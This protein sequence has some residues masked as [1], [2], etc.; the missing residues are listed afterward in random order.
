VPTGTV[1]FN[2]GSTT[3]GT[4]TL[5]GTG[6]AS[7]TTS[8]LGAGT[9][10]VV[11]AYLGDTNFS[12]A[13]SPGLSQTINQASYPPTL[14]SSANPSAY[15]QSVTFTATIP[16][17]NGVA[18]TGNITFKDGANGLGVMALSNSTAAITTA[19]L[20]VGTHIISAL[21]SGDANFSGGNVSSLAVVVNQAG[22]SV[23]VVSSGNPSAYNQPV[24]FTATVTPQYGGTT[25]GTITFSDSGSPLANVA[26]VG[27]QA[28]FTTPSL[29]IG[30]HSITAAYSGDSNFTGSTSSAIAQLVNQAS[31]IVTVSSSA[32]PAV[33]GQQ[34]TFTVQVVGQY[35]GTLSGTVTFQAGAGV[36]G[37][38]TVSEGV[39]AAVTH[40]F[41]TAAKGL[42]TAVYSGDSNFA[43]SSAGV[44]QVINKAASS[45]NLSSNLNPSTYGQAVSFT[46]TVTS[47][48]GA[49]PS[50]ELVT[51]RMGST[52]LGTAT[53]TGGAATFT[54]STLGAGIR[55]V[56]A[57]Y[58]GDSSLSPST[59]PAV[60]ETIRKATTTTA[61]SSSQNPSAS[62]QSVTFTVTVAGLYA[63]TPTG[64]I[65]FTDNATSLGTAPLS[66]GTATLTTSSLSHGKHTIKG[67]Y[68]GDANFRLS[69]KG[70]SQTVN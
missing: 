31:S 20:S 68:G 52:I 65:T 24:P 22:T 16:S 69:L 53:L 36:L 14:A 48:L 50:G 56:K 38:L 54:T 23:V 59:S 18:A 25:S 3:L 27:N 17:P 58:N 33:V 62:G 66:V 34:V 41:P 12:P 19:A 70:L 2:D 21:Y 6:T 11:A 29:G 46:A 63:G 49:P 4:G 35:G 57:I 55:N 44:Y 51:F 26:L 42:I 15:N 43:G 40:T 61:I 37:T 13:N 47:Y 1:N 39:A 7:F 45:T 60:S 9:H 30:T 5:D 32:N 10:S 67:S 64:T 28:T 8:T